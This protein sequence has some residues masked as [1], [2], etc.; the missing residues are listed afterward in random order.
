MAYIT[1]DQ[2]V[3]AYN[4]VYAH[5]CERNKDSGQRFGFQEDLRSVFCRFLGMSWPP[6]KEGADLSP[7][8][9][10]GESSKEKEEDD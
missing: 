1:N 4:R 6:V 9:E 7:G 8:V 10:E 3:D 2:L 5:F